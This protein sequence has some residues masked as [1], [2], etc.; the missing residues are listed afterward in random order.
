[1]ENETKD[2]LDTNLEESISQESATRQE[3]FSIDVRLQE[4]DAILE[5]YEDVLFEKEEYILSA[6]E[7][8]ILQA[9]YSELKANKKR[10]NKSLKKSRWE[11]IPVWMGIYAVFQFIFSFLFIQF[12][13]SLNFAFWMADSVFKISNNQVWLFYVF[14]FLL[15]V[16]SLL[17]SLIILLKIKNK[18]RKKAFAVIYI[19]QGIE[20]LITIIYMIVSIT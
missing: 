7:V 11:A 3:I 19:I 15:P 6:E 9:E 1:M 14:L 2:L 8:E 16:L 5:K 18:E 12:M 4:I 20:T 17:A 13:I 10:L